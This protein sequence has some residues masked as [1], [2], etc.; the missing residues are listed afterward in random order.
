MAKLLTKV[1][2]PVFGHPCIRVSRDFLV[3]GS[4]SEFL[5]QC[6]IMTE[7]E[8]YFSL[9]KDSLQIFMIADKPKHVWAKLNK[10]KI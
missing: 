1:W 2:V 8:I 10:L 7:K 3:R 5:M 6:I 9:F 4:V